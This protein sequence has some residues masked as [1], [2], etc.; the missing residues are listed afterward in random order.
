MSDVNIHHHIRGG[1]LFLL[2]GAGTDG[3]DEDE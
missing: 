3:D 1:F 2:S